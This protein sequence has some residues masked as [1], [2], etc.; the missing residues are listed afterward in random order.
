MSQ[1]VEFYYSKDHGETGFIPIAS[2]HL[3]SVVGRA[4]D[5][6][7]PYEKIR[8]LT[9]KDIR[10]AKDEIV[11]EREEYERSLMQHKNYPR[12]A[13]NILA[14]LEEEANS[15][16]AHYYQEAEDGF[17]RLPENGATFKKFSEAIDEDVDR[18]AREL[19]DLTEEEINF[20]SLLE[21]IPDFE[22]DGGGVVSEGEGVV[23][24]T[25]SER[26]SKKPHILDDWT[27]KF[28]GVKENLTRAVYS[29]FF[30]R[31]KSAVLSE[32]GESVSSGGWVYRNIE[33]CE[34]LIEDTKKAENF[35]DLLLDMMYSHDTL[36][37][38]ARDIEK[39]PVTGYSNFYDQGNISQKHA[40]K[41]LGG[42]AGISDDNVC[43]YAGVEIFPAD[44]NDVVGYNETSAIENE[45]V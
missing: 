12:V 17:F 32:I 25:A 35:C 41:L 36:K 33:E 6:I 13:K 9:E 23:N 20:N 27:K 3:D 11:K 1:Y 2:H 4:F 29:E 10:G 40:V 5:D 43:I 34:E 28:F 16:V 45:E 24:D 19:M 21:N 26:K 38:V 14:Y 7:A 31:M 22:G 44:I 30:D 8:P 18:K 42:S 15:E 39:E 37:M